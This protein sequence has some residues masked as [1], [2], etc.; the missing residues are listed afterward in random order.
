MLNIMRTTI[1]LFAILVFLTKIKAQVNQDSIAITKVIDNL[2]L[3]MKNGDSNLVRNSFHPN[4]KLETIFNTKTGETKL[5]EENLTNFLNVVGTP[6]DG[7]WNEKII[8]STIQI[9]QIMAHVWA[10]YKFYVDEL[11]IHCGVNSFQL[12]KLNNEWKIIHLIDTRRKQ[13]CE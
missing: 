6:H 7:I 2:F 5:K 12:A 11:F 10:Y 8:N 4:V 13:G 1:F 9:D 3:G